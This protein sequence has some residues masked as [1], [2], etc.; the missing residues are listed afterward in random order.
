MTP[1]KYCED[2]TR[3]SGSSFFYA[4]LFLSPEKRRAMMALYAFCREVDDIADEIKDKDVARTKLHFWKQEIDRVYAD[5]A[6][7]PV[8]KELMWTKDNF[9]IEQS[10]LFEMIQG[11]LMDV[12]GKA[13]VSEDDLKL[14][15]YRV[16]GVV[17]LLSIAVFGFKDE[18]SKTFALRMG[19]A[20]QLT[21]I[22]RDVYED[23]KINRIYLPQQ[24]RAQFKVTDQD[25]RQ[26][27]TDNQA[28]N[29]NLKA[30][31]EYYQQ[32]A[33]TAYQDALAALPAEDRQSL[34]PSLM[35]GAIY[36]AHLAKLESI[37]YDVWNHSA[38][39][40]PLRKI[41]VAWRTWRYEKKAARKAPA[42]HIALKL[43]F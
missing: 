29:A 41:W 23:T 22:L 36:Y 8:G 4:F 20:L 7:H 28:T 34:C 39:L 27:F 35:M 19:D 37:D 24:I 14:Y 15:C 12:E 33:H 1:E 32:Q 16:A 26:G 17:G 25:I 43:D 31:F 38:R 11:M 13:I 30:L 10:L 6:R 42:H 18:Q 5:K 9:P 21:N 2:K 3:G 40:S